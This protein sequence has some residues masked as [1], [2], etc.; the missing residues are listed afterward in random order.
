MRNVLLNSATNA[1]VRS[2][3]LVQFRVVYL[4]AQRIAERLVC[5]V[6]LP[7]SRSCFLGCGIYI[8]VKTLREQAISAADLRG[9][10]L[11]VKAEGC[12]EIR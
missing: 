10:T 1:R 3:S 7:R 6:Q 12:V 11:P 5:S 4:P 8:G 9:R 2:L